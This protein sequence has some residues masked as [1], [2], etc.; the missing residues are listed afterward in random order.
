MENKQLLVAEDLSA[1]GDLS[2]TVATPIL[3]C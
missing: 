3:Q 2:L 1:V